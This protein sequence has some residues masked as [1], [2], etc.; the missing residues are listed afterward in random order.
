VFV[1]W[2]PRYTEQQ[3]REAIAEAT[4]WTEVLA[5]LGCVYHGKNLATV[6]KW[7]ARWGVDI[8]HL[9][10]RTPRRISYGEEE[11]RAAVAASRSWAEALR[12]L[13]YSP[14]GGNPRTLQKRVAAWGIS[15][16]HFDPMRG[17][18]RPR[19]RKP[20]EE[21]LVEG[22]TYSRSSLKERL[23]ES[24]LKERRCELCGQEEIWQGRRMSLVLDHINGVRDDNRLENLQIVCPNCAATLETHCGRKNSL[25]PEE[26]SCARCGSTFLRKRSSQRFCSRH[27]GT[28]GLRQA[29]Q[30]RASRPPRRRR[31]PR[32]PRAQLLA[33]VRELGYSGTGRRHGVSDNA[34]RKW[35]R[36]YE[37]ELAV[38]E[39][40]DP[41]L[42][43]IPKR[44][45]PTRRDQPTL[46]DDAA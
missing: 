42:V 32:P 38:A 37:R 44:T 18:N 46:L 30:P 35:L 1:P 16:D 5:A 4:S 15:T 40:R 19:R 7:A 6:R 3:A 17:R 20:L 39:G 23:Y 41:D 8:S 12:K 27:C 22:S 29:A 21:I 2:K 28:R 36:E 9:A 34:I 14:T 31:K 24:G 11:A 43:E 33:Q 45:W 10:A 26:A 13:G 25:E